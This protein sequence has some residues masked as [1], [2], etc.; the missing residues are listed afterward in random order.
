MQLH[1]DPLIFALTDKASLLLVVIAAESF[2][3]AL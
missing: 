1:D 2:Y 3:L